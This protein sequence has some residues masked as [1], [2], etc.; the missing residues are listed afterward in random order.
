MYDGSVERGGGGGS[1]RPATFEDEDAKEGTTREEQIIG[2][3]DGRMRKLKEK[4]R[5]NRIKKYSGRVTTCLCDCG[6]RE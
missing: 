1:G 3:M 6:E 2:W 5:Y 4:P